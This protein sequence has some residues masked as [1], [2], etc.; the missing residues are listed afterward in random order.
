MPAA[1]KAAPKRIPRRIEFIVYQGDWPAKLEAK[2]AE[3]DEAIAKDKATLPRLSSTSEAMTVAEEY[4]ALVAE[5]KKTAIVL[6]LEKPDRDVVATLMDDFPPRDENEKKKIGVNEQPFFELA[7]PLAV[8]D[9]E[10]G[11]PAARAKTPAQ[12]KKISPDAIAEDPSVKYVVAES[13]VEFAQTLNE[14]EWME[15]KREVH[16]LN[17]GLIELPKGSLV[18][19]LRALSSAASRSQ[20][21]GKSPPER[22]AGGTKKAT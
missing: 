13:W 3:V 14:S 1:K 20:P 18:S 5:A 6:Q 19:S 15:L 8:V 11:K 2:Y 9:W 4:D 17:T 7:V 10:D 12:I 22:L 16:T 21:D